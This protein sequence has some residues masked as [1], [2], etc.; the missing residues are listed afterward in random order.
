M[1]YPSLRYPSFNGEVGMKLIFPNGEH[2][3]V[4][5]SQGANRIGSATDNGVVLAH[6]GI[7]ALH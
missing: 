2:P 3:Q 6:P 7:E 1:R 4:L 5:L